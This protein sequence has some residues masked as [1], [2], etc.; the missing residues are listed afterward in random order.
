ML[1][2]EKNRT[3]N[4]EKRIMEKRIMENSFIAGS[5]AVFVCARLIKYK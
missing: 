4:M 3:M 2:E 5:I 1:D